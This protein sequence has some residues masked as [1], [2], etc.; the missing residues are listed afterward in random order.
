[1]AKRPFV[2]DP[3]L[4][5][6][7]IGYSNPADTLIAD[8]VLPRAPVGQEAFKWT[9]YPLED[10][11]SIDETLVGRKGK[12]NEVEFSGE[13]AES[14]V[15][16]HGL[17]A[18]VVNSDVE[19]A[20][21]AREKGLSTYDPEARAVAGLTNRI[22]LAREVR[23]ASVIQNPNT[24]AAA[25]R[26][27][28]AGNSQLSD[29]ANSDPIGVIQTALDG[30]LVYRPNVVT[31][32]FAAWSAIRRHPKLLKA[33]KGGLTDEGLL[34]RQQFADLFEIPKVL[35]G[36]SYVNTSKK[37]QAATL[38]RCWGKHISCLYINPEATTQE[39][40]TFGLTA[41]FGTRIAGRIEDPDIGLQGGYRVR[42]G[43]RVRELVVAP[44]VGYF[45]Q[46]AV[47]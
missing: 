25:R 41:Q 14:S 10:G 27:T 31:M 40:I 39:G 30:T 7:A 11:F 6:I 8:E 37:G 33:V 38:A 21:A 5:A 19:A 42:S 4:T 28:L 29:Y 15:Q 17:D 20:R 36:S 12:P 32:G 18:P 45:I 47:A 23:V 24:Y 43:E 22:Q 13:E 26:V 2:V 35:I 9:K 46:N 3:V 1:M 16:D 34:T 44:D